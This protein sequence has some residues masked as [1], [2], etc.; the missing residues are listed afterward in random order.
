[1][2]IPFTKM[3]GCGNDYVYLDGFAAPLP[4][5]LP[6]LARRVSDRHVGIGADGL[7]AIVPADGGSAADLRMI[8]FNADGSSS[9]MC[10]NG[11]RCAAKLAWDHQRVTRPNL[12]VATGAG[13]KRIELVFSDTVTSAGNSPAKSGR[14]RVPTPSS[15]LRPTG[16]VMGARVDMGRPLLM[17][18]EVPVLHDGPGPRLDLTLNLGGQRLKLLAVGMGNPHAVLFVG[19]PDEYPVGNVGPVIE[20]HARFPNRTNVE[21][22]ALF[23]ERD[24]IP[25]IRQRTWERGSG[26][27]Q[28]CGT[29]ACATTV[30][31]ILTGRITTRRAI[32]RLDGGDLDIEWASDDAPVI[33]TGP[34]V[35]VFEGVWP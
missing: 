9:E 34:A 4:D 13:D 26:E 30:A 25:I 2:P 19:N 10:G 24:G 32:I 33:M 20:R 12:T 8:M 1:M 6:E 3:H 29:G 31:A 11:I 18:A 14:R 7:I 28:A 15:S 16:E 5:D 35:T 22:A 27:T 21:F 23:S 17:P